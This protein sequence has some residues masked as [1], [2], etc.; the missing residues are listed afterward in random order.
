ADA[1][2]AINLARLV[3]EAGFDFAGLERC[4]AIAVRQFHRVH[5][6]GTAADDARPIHLGVMGL[7]DV[8]FQLKLPFDGYD[9]R[10]LSTAIAR[11]ICHQ[12]LQSSCSDVATISICGDA[13]LALIAGCYDCAE[14]QRSNV[15]RRQTRAGRVAEIN[16]YLV[17]DLKEAGVWSPAMREAI[18]RADGSVQAIDGIPDALRT[19]YRTAWELSG[20]ALIDLAADRSTFVEH[21]F[22]L[23]L[24]YSDVSVAQLSRMY[25]YAW[26]S[27]LKATC[28]VL[29]RNDRRPGER[30]HLSGVPSLH[31]LPDSL[32]VN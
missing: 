5:A 4:V 15:A 22:A 28:T 7:Q 12:A 20:L 6:V 31:A 21:G 1:V 13:R 32:R 26:R 25:L 3:G 14:P 2:G 9:A 24:Y 23:T 27:G 18:T 17:E 29:S 8:F 11:S 19:L 10:V 16:R 30:W